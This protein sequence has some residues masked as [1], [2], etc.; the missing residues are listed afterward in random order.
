ML[1]ST[2][3]NIDVIGYAVARILHFLQS[4]IFSCAGDFKRHFAVSFARRA[5]VDCADLRNNFAVELEFLRVDLRD[6]AVDFDEI[7]SAALALFAFQV[8][9]PAAISDGRRAEIFPKIDPLQGKLMSAQKHRSGF[10]IVDNG[11][12]LRVNRKAQNQH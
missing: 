1:F 9:N 5:A 6:N 12:L 11:F 4:P 3:E 2:E 10:R 7:T 8:K